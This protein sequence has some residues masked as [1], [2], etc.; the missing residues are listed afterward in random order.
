MISRK[1]VGRPP[2]ERAAS[3]ARTVCV[4]AAA[5]FPLEGIAKAIG[6]ARHTMVR[7]Y[8]EEL[9]LGRVQA[10]AAVARSLFRAATDARRPNVIACIFWLKTRAG[11]KEAGGWRR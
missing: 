9:D 6:L 1:R 5:G 11:W 3:T 4:L 2:I 8:R 10:H 7:L